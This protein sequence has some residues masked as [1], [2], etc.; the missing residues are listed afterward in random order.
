M[1]KKLGDIVAN[2]PRRTVTLLIVLSI[3]AAGSIGYFGIDQEF[4][5]ASF[6]PEEEAFVAQDEISELFS[7]TNEYRVTILVKSDDVLT[8]ETMVDMLRVKGEIIQDE[9]IS[10]TF[11][12]R[13]APMM[14]VNSVAG[15]VAQTILAQTG[16]MEPT[17]EEMIGAL[18]MTDDIKGVITQILANEHTPPQVKGMFQ[19]LLT[20]DFDPM[21]GQVSAKGTMIVVSLDGELRPES[22]EGMTTEKSPLS[23]SEERMNDIV[24]GMDHENS[25]IRVMGMSLI[26]DE[27]MEASN[28]NM[29]ILLPIAFIMV[30]VILGLVFRNIVEVFICLA[31]LVMGILW[32]YGFGTALGFSFNPMTI[33]VPILMVGLGIDYGIHLTMR[34]REETRNGRDL[35][36]AASNTVKFVGTALL[37]VTVTTVAA[38]MSNLASP[39]GPLREFGIIASI[40]IVCCFFTMVAFVPACLHLKDTRKLRNGKPKKEV[41]KKGAAALYRGISLGAS[42]TGKTTVVLILL[43]SLV[44]AGAVYG[45]TNL[46]TRF[47]FEDFLPEGL[48]LTDDLR[49]MMNEFAFVSGE[50]EVAHVLVKGD[51]AEPETFN[52][53]AATVE[54]LGEEEY[55]LQFQDGPDVRWIGAV[56]RDWATD[57]AQGGNYDS[58]FSASYGEIFQNDGRLSEHATREDLSNLYTWLYTNSHLDTVSV[59]HMNEYGSYDAAVLRINMAVTSAEPEK[60]EVFIDRM[61]GHMA[62]LESSSESAVLTGESVVGRLILNILN[63]SA[64]NS[65]LL[66]L[67]V[68]TIIMVAV[69]YIKDRSIMLGLMTMIPVIFCVV[70]ILGTMYLLGISLNIM[71]LMV[72][73]LTIGI[74]VDY[75]IHI[76]NR[77]T[78]DLNNYDDVKEAIYSTVTNTGL[79]LFGGAVS[80]IVGFG[81]LAF[82][83]MPPI[84]QFG[85]ITALTIMYSS[86]AAVYLLPTFL[87]IWSKRR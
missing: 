38:F 76:S 83:T 22:G 6:M 81:L 23:I 50:A 69:F 59:L 2:H 21:T 61:E 20:D 18:S 54:N 67:L 17:L 57:D 27:I 52:A 13:E 85:L 58:N 30:L 1:M 87:V 84:A 63:E 37:L 25:E 47:D 62:P 15:V 80:T 32:M 28:R 86:I 49:F 43:V 14:N 41:S 82:A 19:M 64:M 45:A 77:F 51:I 7:T 10:D 31:A 35:R 79:P 3:L 8:S 36:D 42:S 4:S 46:E 33:V 9:Y 73:S 66:T 55:V 68:C 29:F 60:V 16:N 75:G 56:M 12:Y 40:G 5:E 72:T 26:M 74:G 78:E 39:M 71:T 24:E 11:L 48:P 44:T 34:H 53:M 70:W 65:L